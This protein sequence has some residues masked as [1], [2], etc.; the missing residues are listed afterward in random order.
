MPSIVPFIPC[1]L[2]GKSKRG[3]VVV[4]HILIC[5]SVLVFYTKHRPLK[6]LNTLAC[7]FKKPLSYSNVF[8]FH[9]LSNVLKETKSAAMNIFRK[10]IFSFKIICKSRIKLSFFTINLFTIAEN[11]M[12]K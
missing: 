10:K 12:E 6:L 4:Y 1:C 8:V 11:C 2:S 9:V 5:V 3:L 7:I